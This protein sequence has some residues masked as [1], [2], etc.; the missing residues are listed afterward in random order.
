MAWARSVFECRPRLPMILNMETPGFWWQKR[1]LLF[2]Q[3]TKPDDRTVIWI[4]EPIGNRGKTKFCAFLCRNF[5]YLIGANDHKSDCSLW[6][7]Q[8]VVLVDLARCAGKV[9][10]AS[11][12][13]YKN[14]MCLQ[15]KYEVL[16]KAYETPHLVVFSNEPP[17]LAMLSR[18][19]WH[20]IT[21][22]DD[23]QK[24]HDL[25]PPGRFPGVANLADPFDQPAAQPDGPNLLGGPGFAR[26]AARGARFKQL[27]NPVIHMPQSPRAAKLKR[28][29]VLELRDGYRLADGSVDIERI[30]DLT[31]SDSDHDPPPAKD[32]RTKETAA[33]AKE[34]V[35]HRQ[36]SSS[37]GV[38]PH[39]DT[40]LDDSEGFEWEED[41]PEGTDQEQLDCFF[42]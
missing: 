31:Q 32:R 25:F 8:A 42:N 5:G 37:N 9:S 35:D 33:R 38:P 14:G 36:A 27:V 1:V 41:F 24:L 21:N 19:R 39:V 15:T 10:Y 40:G 18:D 23:D 26:R 29:D 17:N 30:V 12:E 34:R 13:M 20:V 16:V 28:G 11:L 6:D 7:G 3:Q 22:L 4:H 2:L